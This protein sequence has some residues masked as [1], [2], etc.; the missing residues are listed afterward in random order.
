MLKKN[1]VYTFDIFFLFV[2]LI[3][4]IFVILIYVIVIVIIII[5][6][7]IEY[8]LNTALA[9]NMFSD[10]ITKALNTHDR[11]TNRAFKSASLSILVKA[12]RTAVIVR[13][14]AIQL[15]HR[16]V[17]TSFARAIAVH[18][19]RTAHRAL[20]LP[21]VELRVLLDELSQVLMDVVLVAPRDPAKVGELPAEVT[22]IVVLAVNN[23]VVHVCHFWDTLR[24]PS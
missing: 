21:P 4:L 9:V 7:L 3:V 17:W 16:A 6:I 20:V 14:F 5:I 22:D 1:I 2:L 13:A 11:F 8:P 15:D 23:V 10:S 24:N 18:R 19:A 12:P